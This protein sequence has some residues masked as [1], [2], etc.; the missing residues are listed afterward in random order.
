MIPELTREQML[1]MSLSQMH[2]YNKKR[3]KMQHNNEYYIQHYN[4]DVPLYYWKLEYL[5]DGTLQA[6]GLLGNGNEWLTS[7]FKLFTYE[8]GHYKGVTISGHVYRLYPS[9]HSQ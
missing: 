8:S 5:P 7:Y 3:T 2:R 6:R 1:N 4:Y 9:V